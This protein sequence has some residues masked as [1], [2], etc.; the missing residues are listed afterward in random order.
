DA[1]EH[2]CEDDRAVVDE[3]RGLRS[4]AID[5]ERRV[6]ADALDAELPGVLA[7]M[8]D[9]LAGADAGEL[10]QRPCE[11]AQDARRVGGGDARRDVCAVDEE[12]EHL[13]RLRPPSR[14]R[15]RG[16]RG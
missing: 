4:A 14:S 11:I 2:L 12:I 3:D 8:D 6:R 13:A 9:A 10:R 15:G 7:E 16:V 5:A 1:V